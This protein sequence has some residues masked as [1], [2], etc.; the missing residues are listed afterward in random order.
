VAISAGATSLALLSASVGLY[1]LESYQQWLIAIAADTHA[2]IITDVSIRGYLARLGLVQY[3]MALS[4]LLLIGMAFWTWRRRLPTLDASRIGIAVAIL[5]SPLAWLHYTLLLIPGMLDRRANRLI[6][7]ASALL[8]V[9]TLVP[10]ATLRG[11]FWIQLF[12]GSI[13]FSAVCLLLIEFVRRI[14]SN[15]KT[16]INPPAAAPLPAA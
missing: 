12:G 5:A 6:L 4:G 1:G 8:M 11:G 10:V 16:E 9:P 2:L 3:G 13:Y 7:V 15:R 14:P